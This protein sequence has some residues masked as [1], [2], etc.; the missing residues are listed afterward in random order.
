MNKMKVRGRLAIKELWKRGEIK[1]NVGL[2]VTVCE[3]GT[4]DSMR[5]PT[6]RIW[7]IDLKRREKGVNGVIEMKQK[8]REAGRV[9]AKGLIMSI[10]N[11]EAAV[12]M[13]L[14]S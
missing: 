9:K 10:I 2:M 14:S 12:L 7:K 8:E 13:E 1:T 4:A 6:S 11:D 5:R 3:T